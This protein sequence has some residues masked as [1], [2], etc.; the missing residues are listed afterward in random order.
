MKTRPNFREKL[1]KFFGKSGRD[2]LKLNSCHR[3]WSDN[4][5]NHTR[6]DATNC[7]Y[8]KI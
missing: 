1:Y 8:T 3:F 4:G 5:V 2:G 7:N 6:Y